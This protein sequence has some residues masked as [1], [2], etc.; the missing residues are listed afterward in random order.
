MVEVHC[1][2]VSAGYVRHRRTQWKETVPKW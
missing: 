2:L 1:L